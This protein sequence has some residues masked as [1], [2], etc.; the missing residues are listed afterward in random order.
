M[1]IALPPSHG[2]KRIALQLEPAAVLSLVPP[3]PLSACAETVPLAWRPTLDAI[4]ELGARVGV[5]VRAFGAVAWSALSGLDYLSSSS[6]LD[7][8]FPLT[9]QT[10]VRALLDG[11]SLIEDKAP[12]RLD[13]EVIRENVGAVHWRELSSG[14]VEVLIKSLV[15]A[16]IGRRDVFLAFDDHHCKE[17]RHWQAPS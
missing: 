3:P 4:V 17:T 12:M 13:G 7:L 16:A 14:A 10:P 5:E 11:L 1:G 9:P 6:D 15:G 8:L 2:K